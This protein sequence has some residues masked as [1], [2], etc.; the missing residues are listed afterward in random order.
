MALCANCGLE[1]APG[2][3]LCRRCGPSLPGTLEH[4]HQPATRHSIEAE[5]AEGRLILHSA[6]GNVGEW[7]L[8]EIRLA[9]AVEG[10][11]LLMDGVEMRLI[12]DDF[13]GFWALVS[14]AGQDIDEHLKAPP[15]PPRSQW[16]R[17]WSDNSWRTWRARR[18]PWIEH[19]KKVRSLRTRI[20]QLSRSRDENPDA[21]SREHDAALLQA[22]ERQLAEAVAP[23]RPISPAWMLAATA[24]I[25]ALALGAGAADPG[26]QVG[27]APSGSVGITSATATTARV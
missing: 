2:R 25:V 15:D 10:F 7:S 18:V 1:A 23:P 8:A 19:R 6:A 11:S 4:A 17:F 26:D 3:S 14:A 22:A 5:V 12:V 21:R 24:V 9:R 16:W 20:D 27:A 13:P